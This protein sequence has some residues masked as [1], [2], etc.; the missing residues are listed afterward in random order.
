MTRCTGNGAV[1]RCRGNQSRGPAGENAPEP[2][3]RVLQREI[4]AWAKCRLE[5]G[6]LVFCDALGCFS[7]VQRAGC[8]H[9][10]FVTGGGPDSA[11]HP[12][13]SWVNTILGNIKR[14][15]HGSYHRVSSKHLP[16]Y[17]AEFSYRFNRR[18]SLREMFPR[19]VHVALRTPPVPNRVL[20]LAENYW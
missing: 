12:A 11:Q 20:K 14:S 7:A 8:F 17:L 19:L 16:R 4:A 15:L 6:T 1:R 13:L 2:R 10:P 9:Q 5:R 3:P 18:F